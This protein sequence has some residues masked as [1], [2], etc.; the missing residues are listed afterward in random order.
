MVSSVGLRRWQFTLSN[1]MING[2]RHLQRQDLT[3]TIR[4][5]RKVGSGNTWM[6]SPA[7]TGRSI[8][9]LLHDGV[10]RI[11]SAAIHVLARHAAK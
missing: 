8:V 11:V 4:E 7:S 2:K 5:E 3:L 6:D 10:D 1:L 9:L